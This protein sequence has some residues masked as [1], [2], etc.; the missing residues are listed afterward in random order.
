[1]C[2]VFILLLCT[3]KIQHGAQL[4][5]LYKYICK[6]LAVYMLAAE[7]KIH[8]HAYIVSV[9][10]PK[11]FKHND[12]DNLIR[13]LSIIH[14]DSDYEQS[15]VNLYVVLNISYLALLFSPFATLLVPVK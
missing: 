11:F 2:D 5:C 14:T 4:G 6:T 10:N 15:K 3:R 9:T 8:N 7:C 12:I 13:C 1:M